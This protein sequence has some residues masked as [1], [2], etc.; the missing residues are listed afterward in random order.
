M[1]RAPIA[2]ALLMFCAGLALF[3]ALLRLATPEPVPPPPPVVLP[4]PSA[5]E[6]AEEILE[7][8]RLFVSLLL[9]IIQEENR[10]LLKDRERISRIEQELA[11]DEDIGKDDFDWLKQMAGDYELDPKARRNS[12]FFNSLRNRVDVIPA[13]LIIAQ[14]AIESGWGRSQVTREANNFFGHYCYGKDCGVPAPGVGDLRV[15][16]TAAD[17]VKAYIHNL[18]SHA[19]YRQLRKHRLD[20]RQAGKAPAGSQLAAF[21]TAYSERG[22]AYI[23]DVQTVIRANKLDALPDI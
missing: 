12:E 4:P 8:K 1:Q 23:A 9:P 17:S 15:F 18:N 22:A 6:S 7:R 14:A 13:S 3:I 2:I 10:R 5:T 21:I 20:A 16:D 11:N 19:A